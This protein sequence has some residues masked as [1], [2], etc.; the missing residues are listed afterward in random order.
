MA[1]KKSSKSRVTILEAVTTPL[2]FFTLGILV[3]E[4]I[5]GTLSVRA[6]GNNFTILLV[7]LLVG[8]LMLMLMVFYLTM[9]QKFRNALLGKYDES[10][11][12]RLSSLHL[13]KNDMRV[14]I[15]A[16][17]TW[18]GDAN[19]A[20]HDATLGPVAQS[21]ESR[22]KRFKELGLVEPG[23]SWHCLPGY[24]LTRDGTELAN[25]IKQSFEAARDLKEGSTSVRSL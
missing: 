24:V 19:A 13:S 20:A 22:M 4:G 17:N 18:R 2:G 25:F 14:L 5:L 7:G 6:S 3:I 12:D 8:F 21:V 23:H 1:N 11:G 9:S 16:V 15:L 10:L